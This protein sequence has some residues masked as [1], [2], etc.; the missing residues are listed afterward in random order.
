M[1]AAEVYAEFLRAMFGLRAA[2]SRHLLTSWARRT[3]GEARS[4]RLYIHG[5][6]S[7]ER[8]PQRTR[9][10]PIADHR[11]KL[12]APASDQLAAH[13]RF[14]ERSP[15]RTLRRHRINR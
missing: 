1:G 3:H 8:W 13:L 6:R 2:S 12:V 10:Q 4:C 9:Q 7:E 11:V 5:R 14:R 15:I